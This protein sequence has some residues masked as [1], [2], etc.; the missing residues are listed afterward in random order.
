M[1]FFIFKVRRDKNWR[2]EAKA[3]GSNNN[4]MIVVVVRPVKFN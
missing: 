4:V 3:S 2:G 1:G